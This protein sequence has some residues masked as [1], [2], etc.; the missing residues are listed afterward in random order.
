MGKRW[1][2]VKAPAASILKIVPLEKPSA[3]T[4]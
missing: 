2:I 3:V 1:S 4:P